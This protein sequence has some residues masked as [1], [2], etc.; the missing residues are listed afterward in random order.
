MLVAFVLA[1]GL[2]GVSFTALWTK[3]I[4][5]IA[6]KFVETIGRVDADGQGMIQL[7][8]NTFLSSSH[9]SVASETSHRV[10]PRYKAVSFKL[11]FKV[12]FL[13]LCSSSTFCEANLA[14]MAST[15]MSVLVSF[16][17]V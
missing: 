8:H 2:L 4:T 11:M 17:L 14:R 15:I 3:M 1:F 6:R 13:T 7:Y 16:L 9:L 12:P 5:T 10:H